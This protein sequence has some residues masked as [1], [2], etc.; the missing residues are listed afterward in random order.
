M[1]LG[2]IDYYVLR[3]TGSPDEL[4]HQAISSFLLGASAP[5]LY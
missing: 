1:A 3:P 5:R 4:F 2:R